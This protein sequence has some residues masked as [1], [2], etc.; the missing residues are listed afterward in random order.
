VASCRSQVYWRA[1]PHSFAGPQ[2]PAL[3]RQVRLAICNALTVQ[4]NDVGN[5]PSLKDQHWD[6]IQSALVF[7][8]K[9]IR[10]NIYFCLFI[11]LL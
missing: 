2:I 6:S 11:Y 5:I 10:E 7:Y 3:L 4:D 1:N 8:L 9:Q